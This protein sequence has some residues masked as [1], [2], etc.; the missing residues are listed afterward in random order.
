MRK[1]CMIAGTLINSRINSQEDQKCEVC[2]MTFSQLQ[3]KGKPDWWLNRPYYDK[4]DRNII[5][6]MHFCSANCVS[7]HN[8]QTQGVKGIADRGMRPQDNPKNHPNVPI[9]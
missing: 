4:E 9:D 3:Q 2:K 8:N 6:V 1:N 7:L 5:H